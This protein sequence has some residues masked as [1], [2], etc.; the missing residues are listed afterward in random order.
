MKIARNRDDMCFSQKE[1]VLN[2]QNETR[3]LGY[4]SASTP[5]EPVHKPRKL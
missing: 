3:M 1:Y 5:V 2:L 4:K